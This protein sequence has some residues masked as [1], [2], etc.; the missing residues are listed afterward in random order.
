MKA[1]LGRRVQL[2]ADAIE[3]VR[4]AATERG[5]GGDDSYRVQS[6]YQAVLD[7]GHTGA[8]AEALR[9]CSR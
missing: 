8:G 9:A 6:D 1:V 2:G 7:G 4:Q 3:K 5:G